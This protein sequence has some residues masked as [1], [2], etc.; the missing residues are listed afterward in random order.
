MPYVM[1]FGRHRGEDI[2]RVP[3]DYLQWIVDTLEDN[4]DVRTA[5][6]SELLRRQRDAEQ[7]TE[8]KQRALARMR[9]AIDELPA[10]LLPGSLEQKVLEKGP[11]RVR[12]S[13]KGELRSVAAYVRALER[14]AAE[15]ILA[16]RQ[17]RLHAVRYEAND[18]AVAL[19]V[20]D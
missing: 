1:S 5:A 20:E 10:D 6:E 9:R 17:V 19:L 2:S 3:P 13:V 16:V 18:V 12:W 8:A 4:P 15:D 7:R 11:G 14:D